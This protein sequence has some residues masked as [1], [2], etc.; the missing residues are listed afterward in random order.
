MAL[1]HARYDPD[2]YGVNDLA[3]LELTEPANV[4]HPC[5]KAID[6][7][8]STFDPIANGNCWMVGWGRYCRY[9]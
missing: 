3:L 9:I 8:P 1:Q 4:T 5:I 6:L 2:D 7:G